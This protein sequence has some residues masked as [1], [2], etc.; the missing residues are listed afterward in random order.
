MISPSTYRS[1]VWVARDML[2]LYVRLF[3]PPIVILTSLIYSPAYEISPKGDWALP[4]HPFPLNRDVRA[5]Y[6]S[7]LPFQ[8][9]SAWNGLAVIDAAAFL[10]PYN[11][12]FHALGQDEYSLNVTS[13][14]STSG[15]P[16]WAESPSF[17]EPASGTLW[18]NIPRLGWIEIRQ[19]S[20]IR[21]LGKT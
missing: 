2:G 8:A 16:V 1:D 4:S 7:L 19:L 12:T 21:G 15:G 17:R 10:A 18:P 20:L 5:R 6:D 3:P 11:I 13:S 9:F 14:A